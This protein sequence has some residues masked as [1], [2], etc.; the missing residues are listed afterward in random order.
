MQQITIRMADS[1]DLNRVETGLRALAATLGD[2]Y[3]ADTATLRAALFGACPSCHAAIAL[4]GDTLRGVAVFSPV[5]STIRGHAGLFVSDLWVAEGGRGAGLG[6]RLL[7]AAARQAAQVWDA[8][9]L[10]LVVYDDN[11]GAQRFYRRLGLTPA[12]GDTLMTLD[13]DGLNALKGTT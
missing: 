9:F 11:P 1:A 8:R 2:P 4:E 5:F 10:R 3:R 7:A 12:P 13:E 6:Q